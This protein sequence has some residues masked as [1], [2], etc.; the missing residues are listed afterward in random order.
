[1]VDRIREV[2]GV[3]TGVYQ[4]AGPEE[5]QPG[6]APP[7]ALRL[8]FGVSVLAGPA[9]AEEPHAAMGHA[10][11]GPGTGWTAAGAGA[12]LAQACQARR[13]AALLGGGAHVVDAAEVGSVGLLL[14]AVPGEA[15]HAFRARLLSPLLAYDADHGTELVRTLRVF[16]DCSGSWTKAAETMFVHVNSLR[17]RI[18]RVE[19]LTGR[20]LGS[21]ADQAALLLALRLDG[22][23]RDQGPDAGGRRGGEAGQ[24]AAG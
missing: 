14:A 9:A 17:Y 1:V 3:L 21:L 8:A 12:A 5:D 15:R 23:A 7:G 13:L 24:F 6:R 19:E 2:A 22:P 4:P 20:D 18:R 16:L 10:P 11:P